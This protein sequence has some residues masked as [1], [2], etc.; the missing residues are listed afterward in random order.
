[1]MNARQTVLADNPQLILRVLKLRFDESLS[2]PRIS[3]PTGC[4]QNRHFF[5]GAVISPDIR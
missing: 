1:M 3:A 5:S 4:Q 2:Y